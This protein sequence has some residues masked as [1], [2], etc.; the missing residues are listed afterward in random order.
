MLTNCN[1]ISI[2][3]DDLQNKITPIMVIKKNR[4]LKSF[5]HSTYTAESEQEQSINFAKK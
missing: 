4:L 1:G 3:G 2:A 5:W